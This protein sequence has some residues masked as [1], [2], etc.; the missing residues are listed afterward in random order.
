[1]IGITVWVYILQVSAHMYD[2][3][4]GATGTEMQMNPVERVQYYS[5]LSTESDEGGSQ[6]YHHFI[7]FI[8]PDKNT[9]Q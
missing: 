7:S 4:Q 2:F 3:V 5:S 6:Y 8:E 9:I 1:M